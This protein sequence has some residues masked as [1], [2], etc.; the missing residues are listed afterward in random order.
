MLIWTIFIFSIIALSS[1]FSQGKISVYPDIK[2]FDTECIKNFHNQQWQILK[3]WYYSKSD[4]IEVKTKFQNFTKNYNSTQ[5]KRYSDSLKS[6]H[7]H[8]PVWGLF[9]CVNYSGLFYP[10]SSNV[11]VL[12][13]DNIILN[14]VFSLVDDSFTWKIKKNNAKIDS[15]KDII[16]NKD[17]TISINFTGKQ[18]VNIELLIINVTKIIED[19]GKK[20]VSFKPFYDQKY[21]EM[22][23]RHINTEK[24]KNTI[25]YWFKSKMDS[26]SLNVKGEQEEI[27][28]S[29]VFKN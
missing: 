8:V 16:I 10:T 21:Q 13:T 1:T 15:H 5:K 17:K 9:K 2:P 18:Q 3:P 25:I 7:G 23:G 29:D 6:R 22:T 27:R 12:N 28:Y 19:S 24:L 20:I 4:V 14:S 11:G 26:D